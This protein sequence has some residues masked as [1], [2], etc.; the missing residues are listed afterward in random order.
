MEPLT[1]STSTS[2]IEE[3]RSAFLHCHPDA[4][5][6]APGASDSPHEAVWVRFVVDKVYAVGGF[7]DEHRIGWIEKGVY[8]GAGGREEEEEAVVRDPAQVDDDAAYPPRSVLFGDND[9]GDGEEHRSQVSSPGG[10][11]QRP[12]M[13]YY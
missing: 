3:V 4:S 5:H 12:F 10:G 11:A 8:A 13:P 1:P 9:G 7:G 2:A 6:W